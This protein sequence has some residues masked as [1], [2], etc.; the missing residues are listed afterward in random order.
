MHPSFHRPL[1]PPAAA[2]V[3]VVVV[4]VVAAVA[5]G[6]RR[7]HKKTQHVAFINGFP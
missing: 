7:W 3:V 2:V 5:A 1:S 4:V 6:P